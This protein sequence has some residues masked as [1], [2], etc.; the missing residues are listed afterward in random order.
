MGEV[1]PTVGIVE[2]TADLA[3]IDGGVVEF[4]LDTSYGLTAPIDL[5]AENYRTLILGMKAGNEYHARVV[6]TAG[7]QS[8]ESGDFT[9]TTPEPPNEIVSQYEFETLIPDQVAQGYVI[10]SRWGNPGGP[11]FIFDS[12]NELVWWYED[13]SDDVMRSRMSYDGKY[14]WMRNTAQ[15]DGTG[16]V[17]RIQLDGSD[18]R[19]WPLGTTTHDLAVIPDGNVGLVSHAE[20]G[21]DEILEFDPNTEEVRTVFNLTEAH[22]Q[23]DCHVNAI[24][25][26]D[27]DD[28][29]VVSDWAESLYVKI[30]RESGE[31][32]WIMNKEYGQFEGASWEKQHSMHML[33]PDHILL[34]SNGSGTGMLGGGGGFAG[35]DAEQEPVVSQ[36]TTVFEYQFDVAAGTATELWRYE[37]G[38][39]T[40][41]GGD[42]QRLPNGN[43]LITYGASAE[44]REVNEAG[45]IVR[46]VVGTLGNTFGYA[47]FRTSLYGP[48]PRIDFT[49]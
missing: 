27:Y 42:V 20:N 37:D 29:F 2:F 16:V 35:S 28:S 33:G 11:V 21:C 9:F 23:L 4:G 10:T 19:A 24:V 47:M 18:V 38:P 15:A 46:Q 25:Y 5:S 30:A 3:G 49:L 48:P 8:C 12:D 7:D 31:I 1:V 39:S 14:L 40:M 44:M 43:T 6:A 22:G 26:Q 32:I 34:F 13:D 17:R 45:E 41:Y 36:P